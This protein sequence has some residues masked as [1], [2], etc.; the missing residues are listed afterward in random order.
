MSGQVKD[1]VEQAAAGKLDSITRPLLLFPEVSVSGLGVQVKGGICST[2]DKTP[3]ML[4]VPLLHTTCI[5]HS[6]PRGV[7]G[8][9]HAQ[10]TTT[11][12]KCLLPFKTGAFLAGAPVQ[13]VILKYGPNRV[14]PAWD[15]ITAFWHA[16]LMLANPF[17][18]VTARQVPFSFACSARTRLELSA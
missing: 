4:L 2:S 9:A 13:P 7:Q 18:S 16:L 8:R 6:R 12:G 17:H 11:N 14:S 3:A 10:G 1:R 15:S 5:K